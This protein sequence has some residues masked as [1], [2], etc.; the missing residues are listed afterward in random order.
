[1]LLTRIDQKKPVG[2][3]GTVTHFEGTWPVNAS[4]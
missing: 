4:P 3:G 2:E 1:M